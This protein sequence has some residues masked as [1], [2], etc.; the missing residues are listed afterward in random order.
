MYFP[1]SIISPHPKL[2]R[3]FL[4]IL[5]CIKRIRSK[6]YAIPV[7]LRSKIIKFL[8][9]CLIIMV[10]ALN[11]SLIQLPKIIKISFLS[12]LIEAWSHNRIPHTAY[13]NN[14]SCSII[15]IL[16]I[17]TLINFSC[18]TAF[19]PLSILLH[20]TVNMFFH[21]NLCFFRPVLVPSPRSA[22]KINRF[23][24]KNRRAETNMRIQIIP[25]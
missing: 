24:A 2:W 13:R 21:R 15:H 5:F 16:T 3:T 18:K 17:F 7:L 12:L 23:L 14:F 11:I 4:Y 19:T 6:S 9:F 8:Q 10:Q 20:N 25:I 1:Q 22:I